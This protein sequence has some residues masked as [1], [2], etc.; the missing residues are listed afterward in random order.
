MSC[1]DDQSVSFE[2]VAG[3][4]QGEKNMIFQAKHETTQL[5][6]EVLHSSLFCHD[7]IKSLYNA[8]YSI[9]L[10]ILLVGIMT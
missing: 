7:C 1:S 4:K 6:R 10:S 9:L 8:K 2:T 3:N 5:L